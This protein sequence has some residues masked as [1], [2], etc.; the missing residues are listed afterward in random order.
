[1]SLSEQRY[2]ARFAGIEGATPIYAAV[3]CQDEVE[4]RML[5]RFEGI[6]GGTPIYAVAAS[7]DET[8]RHV[9]VFLGVDV[10]PVYGIVLCENPSSSSSSSSSSNPSSSSSSNPS[11]SSSNP[12]SSNPS[13]SNPSSSN[14]SSSNPSSSN[15]S[16]N[17]SSSSS[18]SWCPTLWI[19]TYR[20]ANPGLCSEPG[21]ATL[22]GIVPQDCPNEL[23]KEILFYAYCADE[24]PVDCYFGSGFDNLRW[25]Q[26]KLPSE[27]A[28]DE[29]RASCFEYQ[30]P[31]TV[32]NPVPEC[33]P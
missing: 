1:V 7:P 14:P 19:G 25:T 20:Y 12:S 28:A 26:G 30:T 17:P 33:C 27:I 21:F 32:E 18:S 29:G 4:D 3:D 5:S 13:S 6:D 15:P 22:V 9:A 11:S 24:K 10:A 31:F 16:S 23:D 8:D 2:L